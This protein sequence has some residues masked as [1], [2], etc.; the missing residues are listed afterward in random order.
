MNYTVQHKLNMGLIYTRH[1]GKKVEQHTFSKKNQKEF[2]NA[3]LEDSA[4]FEHREGRIM[5][6]QLSTL[7]YGQ[8]HE[9]WFLPCWS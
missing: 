5:V 1:T 9:A 8:C 7:W 3:A 4:V 6:W 2:E